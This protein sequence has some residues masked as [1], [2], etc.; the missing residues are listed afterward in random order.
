MNQLYRSSTKKM[1]SGVC[2]GISEYLSVSP[3]IVRTLFVVFTLVS[4]VKYGFMIY[5]AA[6]LL[7]PEAPPGYVSYSSNEEHFSFNNMANKN[8]IGVAF[9]VLGL[10][11]TLKKILNIDDI[12][13]TSVLLIALGIYILVK[14]G[15]SNEEK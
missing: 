1:I 6:M 8:T 10:V 2:G 9:I 3:E 14:G 7:I 15:K 5:I 12:I 11:L 13:V 4:K